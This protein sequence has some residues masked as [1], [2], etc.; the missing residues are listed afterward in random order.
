MAEE[1]L[2]R[3]AAMFTEVDRPTLA[4]VLEAHNGDLQAA[5]SFLL[6]GAFV[7]RA[8]AA[9]TVSPCRPS[10]VSSGWLRPD[11]RSDRSIAAGTAPPPP[12]QTTQA[13][14]HQ[15]QHP[16]AP[17]PASEQDLGPQ[18]AMQEYRI[19]TTLSKGWL[20]KQSGGKTGTYESAVAW[21]GSNACSRSHARGP[22]PVACLS[23]RAAE[24]VARRQTPQ[25]G[26]P[27][28]RA[29][30]RRNLLLQVRGRFPCRP[31]SKG[32]YAVTYL[33]CTSPL[34]RFRRLTRPSVFRCRGESC[35]TRI[36]SSSRW[37]RMGI[38]CCISEAWPVSS[39]RG[40]RVPRNLY[41]GVM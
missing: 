29:H 25:V 38:T 8:V 24:K 16:Q 14:A 18:P 30:V 31:S 36:C 21:L 34:R 9:S 32:M 11:R 28:F 15:P 4:A 22:Y 39:R 6:D 20:E 37:T 10:C 41:G 40:A 13:P 35:S 1:R 2:E 5:A 23:R 27:I 17:P 33:R 7:A 19:Q 26:C 3:L 12:T